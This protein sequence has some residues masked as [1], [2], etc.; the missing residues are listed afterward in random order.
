MLSSGAILQSDI[1][2]A[3]WA[4]SSS[5]TFDTLSSSDVAVASEVPVAVFNLTPTSESF[6][7]FV[8]FSAFD[9]SSCLVAGSKTGMWSIILTSSVSFVGFVSGIVP[10]ISLVIGLCVSSK[11]VSA[12][13][14]GPS[15]ADVIN[16]L[17]SL[18]CVAIS[19]PPASFE[20]V[21]SEVISWLLSSLISFTSEFDKTSGVTKR[22]FL[23]LFT[24]TAVSFG[25]FAATR[26]PS[27]WGTVV[28]LTSRLLSGVAAF[29]VVTSGAFSSVALVGSDSAA[30]LGLLAIS[31]GLAT[32]GDWGPA[33]VLPIFET[34]SIL[35]S[36]ETSTALGSSCSTPSS[37]PVD[38]TASITLGSPCS[39]ITLGVTSG[40]L[41]SSGSW[42]ADSKLV[43]NNVLSSLSIVTPA[44]MAV[45]TALE[46]S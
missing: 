25:K 4:A 16:E 30:I 39:G 31:G 15:L 41:V 43:T 3:F 27:S 38:T 26:G 6:N 29:C 13:V 22:Y 14:L 17:L 1:V 19:S 34:A 18:S 35:A 42:S 21:M 9:S 10:S 24:P 20:A 36:C 45:S 37:A 7:S 12:K 2:V 32:V 11:L 33:S 28:S 46:S 8:S 44:S 23:S 40:T 5:L